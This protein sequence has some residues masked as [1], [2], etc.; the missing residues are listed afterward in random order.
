MG[1]SFQAILQQDVKQVFL[2][3]LELG[4]THL[5]NGEPMT[6]ALDD[7]ENIEREKKMKSHM[8]GI[9]TKQVL[10]YVASADF[11]PLPK[12]GGII[13]LDG[14][15]YTVLDATDECGIYGITMESNRSHG[16]Q[17]GRRA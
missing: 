3:P 16:G 2:N 4:E 15:K 10:F 7:V 6:I 12:E 1:L 11:G 17:G 13:D 5:V 8:D 9:Y 14:Q